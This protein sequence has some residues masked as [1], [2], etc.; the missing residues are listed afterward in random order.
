MHTT[1]TTRRAAGWKDHIGSDAL[2]QKIDRGID[3]Y[4]QTASDATYAP[5]ACCRSLAE[6]FPACLPVTP[7]YGLIIPLFD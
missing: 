3:F 2:D 5:L 7:Y 6:T 4:F 1:R